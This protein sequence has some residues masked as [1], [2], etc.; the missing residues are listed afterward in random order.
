[1]KQFIPVD[2]GSN[3]GKCSVAQVA[4]PDKWGSSWLV[5][6]EREGKFCLLGNIQEQHLK[7]ICGFHFDLKLQRK[8]LQQLKDKWGAFIAS[9]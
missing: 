5:S 6:W 7:Q 3:L 2:M 1:M 9:K 4:A 8:I